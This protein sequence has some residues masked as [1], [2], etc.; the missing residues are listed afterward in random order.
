MSLTGL[1]VESNYGNQA[2]NKLGNNNSIP[3]YQ[4]GNYKANGVPNKYFFNNF[5]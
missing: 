4:K 1:R 5:V 2:S 3:V